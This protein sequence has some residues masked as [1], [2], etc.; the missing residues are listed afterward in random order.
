MPLTAL[1]R[2]FPARP[3]RLGDIR[4][5][6]GDAASRMGCTEGIVNDIV[7]AVDEACQNIIRHAYHGADGDII[8]RM[9][10]DNGRLVVHLIDFA[11]PVDTSKI[12]P[13]AL[14]DLRP[15]GLGTHFMRAIMDEIAFLPPPDGAGNLLQ[16]TKRIGDHA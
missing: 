4:H 2:R 1:D 12:C 13:R 10:C 15:G 16:M 5:A 7:L 9:G 3:D 8:V 14:D 6:V 11:P